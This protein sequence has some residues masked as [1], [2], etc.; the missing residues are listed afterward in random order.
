VE[1]LGK[2][3]LEMY[4]SLKIGKLPVGMV[5]QNSELKPDITFEG[6]THTHRNGKVTIRDLS[7]DIPFGSKVLVTGVSGSGKSTLL[8][9]LLGLRQPESG[10]VT[11]G[12]IKPLD[13]RQS[14][15]VRFGYVSQTAPLI[16]ATVTQNITLDLRSDKYD[17]ACLAEAISIA[18]LDSV[19]ESLPHGLDTVVRPGALSGGQTQRIAIARAIYENPGILILDEATSSLDKTTASKVMAGITSTYKNQT[20]IVVA[21]NDIKFDGWDIKLSIADGKVAVAE[22]GV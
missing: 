2:P 5:I 17:T 12:G 19:I 22:S 16:E 3:A 4:S 21:H 9:L 18:A 8:D 15:P 6:V 11:I 20:L 13:F 7:L 1:E 14:S 10:S